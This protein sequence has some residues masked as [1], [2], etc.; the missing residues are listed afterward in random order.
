[1]D[2]N[3][4][5]R[6]WALGAISLS[7]LVV[8]LDSTVLTVALPSVATALHAT[9]GQL[10]WFAD[11]YL[12][13]LSG[14]LLSAGTLGDRYGRKALMLGGLALFGLG[15]LCCAWAGTP[16]ELIAARSLLG[17]GAAVLIPMTMSALVVMFEPRERRVALSVMGLATMLGLP[18]GPIVAGLLLQHFWWGSVF[19]INLPVILLALAATA[20]L[21]PESRSPQRARFDIVGVLLSAAGLVSVTYGV[22]EGP[23]RGWSDGLVV[24][25]IVG[26]LAVLG[27]FAL[28]ERRLVGAQPILDLELWRDKGFRWG[29]IAAA[30]AS[31][32][33]FG[34]MFA[35]PLYFQAVGGVDALGTGLRTLP[36]LGGLVVGVQVAVR[37][38]ARIAPRVV[39]TAGF[40][41][42]A[43]GSGLGA[44][45]QVDTGYGW[46][47]L[48]TTIVGL[49]MGL[50]LVIAQTAAL[51]PLDKAKAG[52]GSGLLQTLRQAASV[53]GI[54]VLGAVLN[55]VY[56]ADVDVSGL[57][58]TAAAAARDSVAS[59]VQVAR[60]GG[61]SD[62]LESVRS[63]YVHG[64][65]AMLLVSLAVALARCVDRRTPAVARRAAAPGAGRSSR[66][67]PCPRRQCR[68]G[69][70]RPGP[71][72]AC[73]SARRPGPGRS[74]SSTPCG[75]SGTRAMRRRRS[76]RSPR[77]PRSRRAPS[78][79]TS[80]PRATRCSPSS[81]TDGSSS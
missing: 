35:L 73:A 14:L 42:V 21:V 53:L 46:A 17:V 28:W 49:G 50:A 5:R 51:D 47:A 39:A 63:A 30:V 59:G 67:D 22:I 74:S 1:M 61:S 69:R 80:R 15:S 71:A 9:N 23:G 70:L 57:P 34:V 72:P 8:G 48:W 77:R 33:F 11:S 66:I 16:A 38:G 56:R 60:A 37:A 75:C 76:S 52:A 36:M 31:L 58:A 18:L 44:L 20:V 25:A 43:V 64:M 62:L 6:W 13:A 4:T 7:L 45:T 32:A 27:G 78:S 54:A 81:S 3:N 10:Q 26:G 68:A 12:L 41:I 55:A 2:S 24:T 29:A 65:D 40:A 79:A 19:L